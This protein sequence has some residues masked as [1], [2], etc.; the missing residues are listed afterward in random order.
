MKK[1]IMLACVLAMALPMSGCGGK[2][3]EQPETQQEVQQEEEN[4]ATAEEVDKQAVYDYLNNLIQ[5]K[6]NPAFRE[7]IGYE[8]MDI[9]SDEAKQIIKAYNEECQA[10]DE[11]CVEE[12]AEKFGITAEEVDTIFFELN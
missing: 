2:E 5:S 9:N 4:E 12:T 1:A 3:Q 10:Y 8:D 11:K 7:T 6:D